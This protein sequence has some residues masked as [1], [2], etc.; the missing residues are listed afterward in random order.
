M[1][2]EDFIEML[3]LLSNSPFWKPLYFVVQN[4]KVPNYWK[5]LE[6]NQRG[7]NNLQLGL[8][9]RIHSYDSYN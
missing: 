9:T 5:V 4:R 8:L 6:A 1:E 7:Q 2:T 3:P